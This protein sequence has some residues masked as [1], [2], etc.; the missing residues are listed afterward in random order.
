MTVTPHFGLWVGVASGGVLAS[1]T[2]LVEHLAQVVLSVSNDLAVPCSRCKTGHQGLVR[3]HA[4][5]QE[6][7][8]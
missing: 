2:S 8:P 5:L 1:L 7:L 4:Q 3:T 6:T